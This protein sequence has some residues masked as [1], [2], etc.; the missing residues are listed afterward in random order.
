MSDAL[1]TAL[2]QEI[3]QRFHGLK[4]HAERAIAQVAPEAFFGTLDEE[5]NSIGLI[6][7]H[8]GGNLRSRWR[9]F[10]SSDGEKPDRHRDLEFQRTADDSVESVLALWNEGWACLANTLESLGPDDLLRTVHIRGEA[11]TVVQAI[12]RS[13]VHTA[14]HV[15][16]TVLLAKYAAGPG[17]RTLSIPR[18]ASEAFTREM[19][20]RQRGRQ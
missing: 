15:G 1:A 14:G 20:E 13:L 11:H 10:L 9:D 4:E 5:A 6:M 3:R 16:Q 17:W 7:K 2:L 8:V 19:H 12:E 18:G